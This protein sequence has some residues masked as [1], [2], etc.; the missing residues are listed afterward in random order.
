MERK[1]NRNYPQL[2]WKN[3]SSNTRHVYVVCSYP[4]DLSFVLSLLRLCFFTIPRSDPPLRPFFLPSLTRNKTL[5]SPLSLSLHSLS[6]PLHFISPTSAP[7]PMADTSIGGALVPSVKADSEAAAEDTME[8]EVSAGGKVFGAGCSGNNEV[9]RDLV[10][11][12]CMQVMKDA[13]LTACG[14]SY[15]Y[16]CIATHLRNKNDCPSCGRYLTLNLIF[17]N[18][19]VDKVHHSFS[20]NFFE[21]ILMIIWY[22]I[23]FFMCEISSG[24]ME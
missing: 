19:A 6:L 3:K 18:F 13:F 2:I 22:L 23:G 14:H 11:P 17:P 24:I 21:S 5:F 4:Y 15:C 20:L 7:T 9:D 12:I 1:K 8:E 16:M 10:C